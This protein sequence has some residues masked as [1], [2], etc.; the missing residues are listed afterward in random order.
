[1]TDAPITIAA[2][3]RAFDTPATPGTSPEGRAFTACASALGS[4]RLVVASGRPLTQGDLQTLASLYQ[5]GGATAAQAK[6]DSIFGTSPR[7]WA[8]ELALLCDDL[9]KSTI[10][11]GKDL[12]VSTA[13]EERLT[14]DG[15]Y[16][17]SP[18]PIAFTVRPSSAGV[19]LPPPPKA[20]PGFG[21]KIGATDPFLTQTMQAAVAPA[22]RRVAAHPPAFGLPL[23]ST[24]PLWT[25]AMQLDGRVGLEVKGS[26]AAALRAFEADPKGLRL[27][28]NG[29][30]QLVFYLALR[31]A[32]GEAAFDR[33]CAAHG[34]MI[35]TSTTYAGALGATMDTVRERGRFDPG[36]MPPIF[37][38][39]SDADG[40]WRAHAMKPGDA[41]YFDNPGVTPE[42][43]AAG[44]RGEN[45]I[46]LGNGMYF[47][48]PL[49]IVS[50]DAIVKHLLDNAAPGSHVFLPEELARLSPARDG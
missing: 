15:G 44:W 48:H 35:I 1:M 12:V 17:G 40:S 20:S 18:D 49:G 30:T 21:L 7:V 28:C 27:D 34:G 19:T 10:A 3:N 16:G 47:G 46:Y 4:S 26:P 14:V 29:A 24:S 2:P 33:Y 43:H 41:A 8:K 39:S 5:S 6:L 42:G 22:A 32:L 11:P 36:A 23:L 25:Q 13:V 45:V 37:N 50:H 31:D 9:A 38:A